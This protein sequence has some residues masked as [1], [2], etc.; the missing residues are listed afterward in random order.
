M[1]CNKINIIP[2]INESTE[3]SEITRNNDTRGS[4][5]NWENQVLENYVAN[6][7]DKLDTTCY[8]NNYNN[9]WD[10]GFWKGE[11]LDSYAP[12]YEDDCKRQGKYDMDE[13]YRKYMENEDCSKSSLG[14]L[15]GMENSKNNSG[16]RT[17]EYRCGPKENIGG[18]PQGI[19]RSKDIYVDPNINQEYKEYD[20]YGNDTMGEMKNGS[21]KILGYAE[22]VQSRVPYGGNMRDNIMDKIKNIASPYLMEAKNIA[23][24]LVTEARNRLQNLRN[25]QIPDIKIPN[26][27]QNN[28]ADVTN[29]AIGSCIVMV[30]IVLLVVIFWMIFN[31]K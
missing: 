15:F 22:S 6:E 4:P 12:V 18:Y 11:T 19:F 14:P 20:R 27:S 10:D 16:I 1:D 9:Y 24:P 25:I 5:V 21:D 29:M 26:I 23:N 13:E 7:I 8:R 3:G 30:I 31:K 2:G 17:L 28:N